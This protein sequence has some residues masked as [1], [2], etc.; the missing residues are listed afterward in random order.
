MWLRWVSVAAL[1]IFHLRCGMWDLVLQL[2]IETGFPELGAQT[3]WELPHLSIYHGA[4]HGS[5]YL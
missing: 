3:T 5:K 2:R 1:G 4:A